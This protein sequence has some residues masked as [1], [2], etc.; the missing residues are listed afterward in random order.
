MAKDK[1]GFIGLGNMGYP[2]AGHLTKAG[3]E[4]SVYNRT[5]AKADAWVKEYGGIKA[6]T[7]AIAAEGAKIVFA[8]VG[9][10]EDLREIA[11]GEQGVLS[12]LQQGS[13][14]VDHTTA[15]AEV[16]RHLATIAADHGIELL[17]APVSGGQEG[18]QK[19][20]LTVM[21]GGSQD[22]FDEAEPIIKHYA[23]AITLM[24]PI[25]AGQLTK[26]VNQICYVGTEQG[27]AE[28]L[29]FAMRAGLD[30]RRVVNV[31]SK[32]AA[33]S[34]QME[35]RADAMIDDEFNFGFTVD[36]MKKDLR[37]VLDEARRNGSLVPNTALI[38]GY[39]D[40]LHVRGEGHFDNSALIRLL[41]NPK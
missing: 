13:I 16:E 5:E 40:Q 14:F 26:M 2:M 32:G 9:N 18:A 34:W 12:G 37:I 23:R 21:A 1:L 10:D 33:Q 22:A 11:L 27:L 38:E 3:H 35:N 19:G 24:G 8:C 29:N 25:G 30:V 4:V 41:R 6:L 17:D 20:V 7:P 15:S 31:M 28:G 36:W 39:L